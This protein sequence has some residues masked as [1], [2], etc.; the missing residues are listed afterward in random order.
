MGIDI[1]KQKEKNFFSRNLRIKLTK[2]QLIR[3]LADCAKGIY[4][5]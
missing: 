1:I 2:G 5:M 3:A 4:N